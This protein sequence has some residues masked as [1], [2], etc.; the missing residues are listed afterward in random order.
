MKKVFYL[1]FISS[2]LTSFANATEM[3]AFNVDPQVLWVEVEDKP[4][5]DEDWIGVYPKNAS[6]SWSNVIAWKWAR[7]GAASPDKPNTDEYRFFGIADGDYEVR[8]FLNNTFKTEYK[9]SVSLFDPFKPSINI[10]NA[11]PAPNER[12][13]FNLSGILSG[14]QDWVGIYP[15]NASNAWGNVLTWNWAENREVTLTGVPVGEYEARL[16]FNNSFDL[17]AKVA[18]TVEN[19]ADVTISTDKTSYAVNENISITIENQAT[20]NQNWIGIYPAGSS[21]SWGNVLTWEWTNGNNSIN[22]DGVPAGQYEARLFYNNSYHDEAK[23]EFHV[24]QDDHEVTPYTPEVL[25]PNMVKN[26]AMNMD[27]NHPN[28]DK[29]INPEN[30]VNGHL[31]LVGQVDSSYT[32]PRNIWLPH[33]KYTV[34]W[35]MET[36]GNVNEDKF[37]I[38]RFS[39]LGYFSQGY[40]NSVLNTKETLYTVIVSKDDLVN[41]RRKGFS[42]SRRDALPNSTMKISNIRI[43]EGVIELDKP[44][45]K[46]THF[47]GNMTMDKEGVFRR[48]GKTIFP[49]T[50]YK[51]G[52]LITREKR[53]AEQYIAQGITGTLMEAHYEHWHAGRED[54]VSKMIEAGMTTMSV[55]I[56]NYLRNPAYAVG[57]YYFNDFSSIMQTFKQ[58]EQID[59]SITTLTIDNEFYHRNQQFRGSIQE[60]RNILPNKPIQMLNGTEAISAWYNDYI[61]ITGTYIASDIEVKRDH[62]EGT[63]NIHLMESQRLSPNLHVPVTLL[64]MNQGTGENFDAILMA[65]V[66]LGGTKLEYWKDD[67][68][69]FNGFRNLDMPTLPMWNQLPILRTYLDEMCDLGIIETTPYIGFKVTQTH[70]KYEYIKARLGKDDKAYIIA[71]NMT[72][73]ANESIVEF[74]Q[75]YK[76]LHYVPSGQLKDIMTG[77]VKGTIDVVNKKV[78][79]TLAPHT[80]VVLEVEKK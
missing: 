46:D 34:V 51:D 71:S 8:F 5:N 24:M 69:L 15:K 20:N 50:I 63:T 65:G 41:S 73:M 33:H 40:Q 44:V 72:S 74:N 29:W 31:E 78:K 43:Y 1:L 36:T 48:N 27:P 39:S 19:N 64:Q 7:D 54:G 58:N 53:S 10:N 47:Q 4:N 23:Y 21:N 18:F 14:D 77:E 68:E 56:T 59:N 16:F 76:G 37:P 79:I 12:I 26:E 62:P 2:V 42:F 38:V 61:D 35:D 57:S 32:L 22:L 70:D 6:N 75:P 9:A 49:I 17:E 55:P 45:L 13:Q 28:F 25:P 52:S 67:D 60:I 66:A 80:W 11:T 3:T 30:I